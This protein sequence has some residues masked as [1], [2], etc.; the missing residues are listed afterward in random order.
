MFVPLGGYLASSLIFYLLTLFPGTPPALLLLAFLPEG[1]SG[2]GITLT[3]SLFKLVI[4]STTPSER[5]FRIGL[6]EASML[7]ASP[8]G[9]LIGAQVSL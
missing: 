8:I 9:L 4:N 2:A 7:L 3:V 6:A 5:T 1:L